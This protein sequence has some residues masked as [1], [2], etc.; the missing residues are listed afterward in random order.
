MEVPARGELVLEVAGRELTGGLR[1]PRRG[2]RQWSY[3][4]GLPAVLLVVALVLPMGWTVAWVFEP[5][6]PSL[7]DDPAALRAAWHSVLWVLIAVVLL[8]A[9][10][11][12]AVLSRLVS[13]LWQALLYLMILP[14]GVSAMVSGATFRMIFDPNPDRGTVSALLGGANWLG[15]DLVWWVLAS[16][17]AWSWLGFVVVLFRAGLDANAGFRHRLG[18]LWLPRTGP[19]TSIVVLTVLVAAIRVF[20]L[21]LIVS[22]GSVRGDVDVAGLYW[23]RMT[24]GSDD[25]RAP[26]TLA[27]LLFA[28]V[29]ALSLFGTQRMRR[30]A[31]PELDPTVRPVSERTRWWSWV[32]G[33]GVALLWTAPLVVLVATAL[34]DPVP[35]GVGGWWDPGFGLGS[36]AAVGASWLWPALVGNLLVAGFATGF[37]LAIAVPAAYLLTWRLPRRAANAVTA[38]L[39]VLAVAPVQMYAG[40]LDNLFAGGRGWVVLVHVAAG[41][42][43]AIL[44]LRAAFAAAPTRPDERRP[45]LDT[46]WRRGRYRPAMVAVAVLEFVLVWNDFIV[47][48]LIGGPGT[49]PLTL[50]LWGEARQFGISVGTVAAGSV[51]SAVVPVAIL[52]VTWRTVVRGLTGGMTR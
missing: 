8:V 48:F 30:G 33:V 36:F 17:F 5:G 2:G 10:Y 40:P 19:V 11:V 9:G 32:I 7:F 23:W 1:P 31:P 51:V 4:S 12:I 41:L 25:H 45:A 14:F 35:A 42:P 38:L 18:P 47:G 44:V 34:H 49:S 6:A 50:L 13:R 43:F 28:A 29:A 27:V 21:V 15:A 3:L 46:M 52:L 16:A 37:V 20:D 39:G 26:A 24:N 22:P